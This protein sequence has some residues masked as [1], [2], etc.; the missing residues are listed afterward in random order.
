MILICK[1]ILEDSLEYLEI[2]RNTYTVVFKIKTKKRCAINEEIDF[3][4]QEYIN[5]FVIYLLE[6][7]KIS[8]H[9]KI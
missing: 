5:E 6:F 7:H 2:L 8:Y 3:K 9:Y 4:H 1:I